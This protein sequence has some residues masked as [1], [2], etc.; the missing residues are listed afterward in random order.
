MQSDQTSSLAGAKAGAFP[1][2]RV[3]ARVMRGLNCPKNWLEFARFAVV[4]ATGYV[5]NIAVFAFAV[6]QLELDFRLAATCAFLV[7]LGNN[8]LWHRGWTF[9]L[10]REGCARFQ[11]ARFFFVSITA[12]LISLLALNVFVHALHS[13]A[14][15]AQAA[16]I[17][18]ATPLNF[19]GNKLWSFSQRSLF[20]STH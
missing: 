5:V 14:V 18:L 3:F 13:P 15:V 17:L 4:G 10:A 7:A 20:A 1:P 16:S 6:H 12:F 11:M 2:V 9:R 8:F 19:V